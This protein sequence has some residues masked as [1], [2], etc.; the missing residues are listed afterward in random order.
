MDK[1]RKIK[2][3]EQ[4]EE[5]LHMEVK[6]IKN[7][8]KSQANKRPTHLFMFEKCLTLIVSF[9]HMF[10]NYLSYFLFKHIKTL[11]FW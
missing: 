11:K 4:N 3:V 1:F 7:H 2:E 9:C 8:K 5:K 6:K 10:R